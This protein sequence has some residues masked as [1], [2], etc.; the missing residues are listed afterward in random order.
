MNLFE[1]ARFVVS[2]A[3][4]QQ[5]NDAPLAML[6]EVAIVGRSNAGKST[7]INVLANQRQL[8][9]VSKTPGRTQLLNFFELSQ[10]T[11]TGERAARAYL[12]DLPGYGF[13]KVDPAKRAAWD[14]LAGG[15][16][17]VRRCLA[18]VVLVM[19]ARRPLLPVDEALLAWL[20]ARD[21][22]AL[23]LV[24]V[25]T[26]SDQLRRAERVEALRL[27][28]QRLARL[29]LPATALLFSA[30]TREGVDELRA[31]LEA[32]LAAAAPCAGATV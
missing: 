5:L 13:A 11:A 8:A 6:P 26:K 16:L 25:L 17:R 18:G 1:S 2:V 29:P 23:R 9:R 14:E 24:L 21:H 4:L 15:Y 10:K 20:I 22:G 3:E 31:A 30:L 19:D 32:L 12:V 28:E 27:V 7:L